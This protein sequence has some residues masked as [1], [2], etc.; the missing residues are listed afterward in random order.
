MKKI[1]IALDYEPAA[2]KVAESG[3]ELA[4]SLNAETIL[5]HVVADATYYSSL[6]YSPI[7][8]FGGFNSIDAI[9]T[10]TELN[11]TNTAQSFLD[12]TKYHLGDDKINTVVSSGSFS[13]AILLAAKPSY[14]PPENTVEGLQAILLDAK[15]S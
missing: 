2:Q 11:L 12:K 5:L 13:E 9:Q 15:P 8:G 1:L 3:H 10:D 7:M 14:G 6:N 4:K